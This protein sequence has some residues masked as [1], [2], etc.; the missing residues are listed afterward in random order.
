MCKNLQNQ[1]IKGTNSFNNG[2]NNNVINNNNKDTI[3]KQGNECK[4]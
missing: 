2:V 4:S 1:I 3:I